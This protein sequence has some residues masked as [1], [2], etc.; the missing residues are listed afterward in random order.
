MCQIF[1]EERNVHGKDSV[2]RG[3]GLLNLKVKGSQPQVRKM[4]LKGII[5]WT[6]L[7]LFLTFG[8]VKG[9]DNTKKLDESIID[10]L[11]DDGAIEEKKEEA[12]MHMSILNCPPSTSNAPQIQAE[13]GTLIQSQLSAMAENWLRSAFQ[14][15]PMNEETN[16]KGNGGQKMGKK[17]AFPFSQ[18]TAASGESWRKVGKTGA[19]QWQRT[20]ELTTAAAD[21]VEALAEHLRDYNVA[22]SILLVTIAAG[23]AEMNN[24]YKGNFKG[25][26]K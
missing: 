15:G 7:A 14:Q 1:K 25:N 10:E 21:A 19:S 23:L 2:K 24:H 9:M 26:R 17:R 4:S 20:H 12:Q 13:I 3:D 11:S 22:V 16:K 6:I 18:S 8:H 5:K